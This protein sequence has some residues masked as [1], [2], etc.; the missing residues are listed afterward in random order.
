M[1]ELRQPAP[2]TMVMGK[3]VEEQK[4]GVDWLLKYYAHLER[5]RLTGDDDV[6][7]VDLRVD[8]GK[9]VWSLD[10]ELVAASAKMLSS[11]KLSDAVRYFD[12]IGYPQSYGKP[13]LKQLFKKAANQ[14]LLLAAVGDSRREVAREDF[15]HCVACTTTKGILDLRSKLVSS[16]AA[17]RAGVELSDAI[18]YNDIGAAKMD[19]SE[20]KRCG[21]CGKEGQNMRC[22]AACGQVRYCDRD[23]QKRHWKQHKTVCRR[24]QEATAMTNQLHDQLGSLETGHNTVKWISDEGL[25]KFPSKEQHSEFTKAVGA[26]RT[27]FLE[28]GLVA[29]MVWDHAGDKSVPLH[30]NID[31]GDYVDFMSRWCDGRPGSRTN[32]NMLVCLSSDLDKMRATG[33]ITEVGAR[34]MRDVFAKV[35]PKTHFSCCFTYKVLGPF[36]EVILSVPWS[37]HDNAP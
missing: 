18:G 21:N 13:L 2:I 5:H 16:M 15:S 14:S 7:V 33:A 1:R 36:A 25:G 17:K 29:K 24:R 12:G 28:S 32:I 34:M 27:N 22:C 23:C 4:A 8:R 20:R 35:D 31:Y 30:C 37:T 9:D 10:A 26:F 19:N 11:K 3:G 6:I